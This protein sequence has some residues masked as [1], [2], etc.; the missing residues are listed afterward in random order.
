LNPKIK[1]AKVDEI[2]NCGVL[3]SGIELYIGWIKGDKEYLT[4]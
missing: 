1:D 2:Y 4:K 3:S